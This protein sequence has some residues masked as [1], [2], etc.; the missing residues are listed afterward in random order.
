MSVA[1]IGRKGELAVGAVTASAQVSKLAR[2]LHDAGRPLDVMLEVKLSEEQAKSGAAPEDLP[3]LIAAVRDCSNLRLLGLTTMP[4]P[5]AK[6]KCMRCA[7][8]TT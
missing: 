4:R 1:H 2:R 3:D 7:F 6:V 8:L 5:L